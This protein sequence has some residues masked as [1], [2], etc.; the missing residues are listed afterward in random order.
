[1]GGMSG[2]PVVTLL[3]KDGIVSCALC[4]CIYECGSEFEITKAVS[5]DRIGEDGVISE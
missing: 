1:M 2:G 4:G 5:A 3:E